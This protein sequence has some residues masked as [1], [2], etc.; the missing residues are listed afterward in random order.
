MDNRKEMEIPTKA[1][2]EKLL[3]GGARVLYETKEC[4]IFNMPDGSLW[5]VLPRYR[6][7]WPMD[8]FI[9]IKVFCESDPVEQKDRDGGEAGS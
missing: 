5:R 3:L 1:A 6:R 4:K 2:W 7:A 9:Y 8:T